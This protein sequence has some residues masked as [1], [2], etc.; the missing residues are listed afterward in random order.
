MAAVERL[1]SQQDVEAPAALVR[2]ASAE[3]AADGTEDAKGD[4]GQGEADGAESA[5]I[6]DAEVASSLSG[7]EAGRLAGRRATMPAALRSDGPSGAARRATVPSAAFLAVGD[8]DAGAACAA[9]GEAPDE[10]SG[11]GA[12]DGGRSSVRR[13]TMPAAVGSS[14][15]EI[16]GDGGCVDGV[17]RRATVPPSALEAVEDAENAD[18][19]E[20]EVMQVLPEVTRDAS[21][22]SADATTADVA[23]G[24]AQLRAT[25]PADFRPSPEGAAAPSA[26]EAA[27]AGDAEAA[28][29]GVSV[30]PAS[31]HLTRRATMPAKCA[32]AE[33]EDGSRN[34]HRRATLPAAFLPLSGETPERGPEDAISQGEQFEEK[35]EK[36][37]KEALPGACRAP[38]ARSHDVLS[39]PPSEAQDGIGRATAAEGEEVLKGKPMT[40]EVTKPR[41]GSDDLGFEVEDMAAAPTTAGC[42]PA[43]QSDLLGGFAGFDDIGGAA[44]GD[45]NGESC[46]RHLGFETPDPA[47]EVCASS[48][49]FDAELVFRSD[50]R[51]ES[52]DGC[53]ARL[54]ARSATAQLVF[55]LQTKETEAMSA[56]SSAE[57]CSPVSPACLIDWDSFA[58]GSGGS[59]HGTPEVPSPMSPPHPIALDGLRAEEDPLATN[60]DAIQKG[61]P[62]GLVETLRQKERALAA[63]QREVSEL[64][65]QAHA[66]V[67]DHSEEQDLENMEAELEENLGENLAEDASVAARTPVADDVFLVAEKDLGVL[68]EGESEHR[69]V[70]DEVNDLSDAE[71][72]ACAFDGS[73]AARSF[74]RRRRELDLLSQVV[75]QLEKEVSAQSTCSSTISRMTSSDVSLDVS[76]H[77]LW[78]SRTLGKLA[79]GDSNDAG[80]C[81]CNPVLQ[82]TKKRPTTASIASALG[83]HGLARCASSPSS[84]RPPKRL[85]MKVNYRTPD[86]VPSPPS[87]SLAQESTA[88]TM[89]PWMFAIPSILQRSGAAPRVPS[90]DFSRVCMNYDEDD[91][92]PSYEG[93][94]PSKLLPR[95]V[96]PLSGVPQLDLAGVRPTASTSVASGTRAVQQPPSSL[97]NA[98]GGG[99][100][101]LVADSGTPATSVPST[102]RTPARAAVASAK[103]S[104][105]TAAAASVSRDVGAGALTPG[106]GSSSNAVRTASKQVQLAPLDRPGTRGFDASGSARAACAAGAARSGEQLGG[107]RL[108][109]PLPLP[110]GRKQLGALQGAASQ[111]SLDVA[112][113]A[114]ASRPVVAV[115]AAVKAGKALASSA[116]AASFFHVH[117]HFHHHYHVYARG[118][119]A[120]KT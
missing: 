14:V 35:E 54:A 38:C 4:R 31:T 73:N 52:W 68:A 58:I 19:D 117:Q 91:D 115:A 89:E 26:A 49:A 100:A 70:D 109:Q 1:D 90:L 36:E 55:R 47:T 120:R 45:G 22:V 82:P 110:V 116:S 107:R 74:A 13:A 77:R 44:D 6:A 42:S 64:K 86:S 78:L 24:D 32:D 9:A 46:S 118:R 112:A 8:T 33:D 65:A 96:N 21:S 81:G 3:P 98:A 61:S 7:T 20:G 59:D 48:I 101:Q 2:A 27:A 28:A 10:V 50:I 60:Q 12:A 63:L 51:R 94:R 75:T 108:S 80:N 99:G 83:V 11:V 84:L 67:A 37:E 41:C 29:V 102:G 18:A 23:D 57:I 87:P 17:A 79:D 97:V 114:P 71:R 39:T 5:A 105:A 43:M 15:A 30:G 85:Q 104:T 69:S 92:E 88:A 93:K 106:S 40:P 66:A 25:Q 56:H 103:P 34:T 62:E 53:Q 16:S 72:A 95:L 76:G 111:M 119:A 113:A